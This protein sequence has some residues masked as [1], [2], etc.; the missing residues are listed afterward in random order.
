MTGARRWAPVADDRLAVLLYGEV[1]GHL[2]RLADDV[3]GF[4]YDA[5]YALDAE[6]TPLS[7]SLPLL[8]REQSPEAVK[9]WVEGLRPDRDTLREVWAQSVGL[10]PG[11]PVFDWLAGP[12]GLDCA[13]A[14]QFA[15]PDDPAA[16]IDRAAGDEPLSKAQI[17]R[18]LVELLD[19]AN[20]PRQVSTVT[21]GTFSISGAQAKIALRNV[22][23]GWSLPSGPLPT[24]HLLKPSIPDFPG[25]AV[26]E[27]LCM[28]AGAAVGLPT[29]NTSVV[30]FGNV[31]VVV[32]ERF[33]RTDGPDGSAKTVRVH[34]ED[35][36]Q[37]LGV[38]A[39]RKYQWQRG[40]SPE[41][42][43]ALLT[44]NATEPLDAVRS[45][46]EMLAYNFVVLGTDAHAKNFGVLLVR[47]QVGLAPMYDVCSAVPW[48]DD[49]SELGFPMLIGDAPDHRSVHAETPVAWATCGER[50][51]VDGS[52]LALRVGEIAAAVPDALAAEAAKLP[53]RLAGTREVERLLEVLGKRCRR[54]ADVFSVPA[55]A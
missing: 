32:V 28:A 14:V 26:V 35:M 47:T 22:G 54:L 42:I 31:D 38:S 23:D 48:F 39:D 3:V 4:E 5:G 55:S 19:A 30:S 7:L 40:P 13:G 34:F 8:R 27:H 46:A 16:A 17:G 24:T 20:R 25:Q 43:A 49:Q 10:P 1:V 41:D 52:A 53:D 36:C 18:W 21:A 44:D 37:A 15:D 33:D 9:N 50:M 51:G 6:S 2:V 12:L 29:A 45:F 11:A